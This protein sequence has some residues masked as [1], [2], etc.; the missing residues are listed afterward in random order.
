MFE[1]RGQ[2]CGRTTKHP[3]SF[4]RQCLTN[5][6]GFVQAW[7]LALHLSC[8][9][10]QMKEHRIKDEILRTAFRAFCIDKGR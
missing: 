6:G 3:A 2:A 4:A 5:K 9:F 7:T 10:V 1:A 8:C